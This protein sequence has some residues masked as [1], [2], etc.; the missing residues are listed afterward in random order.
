MAVFTEFFRSLHRHPR[1]LSDMVPWRGRA[2]AGIL[3]CK[4]RH[5]LLRSYQLQGFEAMGESREAQGARMIAANDALRRLQGGTWTVHC[6]AQR[7]PLQTYPQCQPTAPVVAQQIDGDRC[8]T[9]VV[10]PGARETQFYVSVTWAPPRL[11][12]PTERTAPPAPGL[13]A[14][15]LAADS[16]VHHLEGIVAFARP[17]RN[18]EQLSYLG[19]AVSG[20]ARMI[21]EPLMGTDLD[22]LLTRGCRYDPGDYPDYDAR[23]GDWHLRCC[24]VIGFPAVTTAEMMRALDHLPLDYRWVTVWNNINPADAHGI[25]RWAQQE[26][27]GQEY[28]IGQR[29][30]NVY[31]KEP[32]RI[33]DESATRKAEEISALRQEVGADIVGIGR[34]SSTIVTWA[35]TAE[36]ADTQVRQVQH[37]L[38]GRG[39]SVMREGAPGDRF[40]MHTAAWLSTLPGVTDHGIRDTL[41]SSLTMTHLWPGLRA[42]WPGPAWDTHLQAGPWFVCHTE[43]H[44]AFN[45]VN[46]VGELGH[47]LCLGPTRSGKSVLAAFLVAMWLARYHDAQ[48]FWFDL[49]RS[50]RLLTLLLGGHHY[51]LGGGRLGFQ[52]LRRIDDMQ[53][54]HWAVQWLVG[55]CAENQVPIT[56]EVQLHLGA[57]IRKLAE[58]PVQDRTLSGLLTVLSDMTRGTELMAVKTDASGVAR[59]DLRKETLIDTHHKIRAALKPFTEGEYGAILDSSHDD[60]A[61]GPVHTFELQSLMTLPRL[62]SPLM[63]YLSF[64]LRQR[65]DTNKPTLW[66][67][68]DAAVPFAFAEIESTVKR[69]LMTAAKRNVSIG[70]YTHSLS[71]VFASALGPLLLESTALKILLPNPAA[72]SPQLAEIYA[73]LGLLPNEIA[74]IATARKQR[75][76]YFIAEGEGRRPLDLP[77]S[78]FL[79]DCLAHNTT[80]DHLLMDRLIEEHGRDGFR[81]AWLAEHGWDEKE[82]TWQ[83]NDTSPVGIG[84][85]S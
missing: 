39:F 24:T 80:N 40:P 70:I 26:N 9:M 28:T 32:G 17:L 63:R 62:V 53:W 65:F 13:R 2:D 78:P 20:R 12:R 27:L 74:W 67:M 76:Y 22:V 72:R 23:L 73:R 84:G 57:G 41:Q 8:Q 79:L 77:F 45:V 51:D 85:C 3:V 75:Q 55:V 46:H 19:Q 82:T 83:S 61:E 38:E 58:R 29:F 5:A 10:E 25:L 42:S 11:Q 56:G 64:A 36:E 21:A 60:L 4:D 43:E 81:A 7:G 69:D 18:S 14:F 37:T 30:Q 50:A 68:D 33:I 49:D 44:T 34:F 31:R 59:P 35:A 15:Q 54:R 6:E 52:P 66:T 16:F 48:S 47:F 71:Q 1:H